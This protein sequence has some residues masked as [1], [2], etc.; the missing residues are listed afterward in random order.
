MSHD[1]DSFGQELQ[2]D[3]TAKPIRVNDRIY[4]QLDIS[5]EMCQMKLIEILD[6]GLPQKNKNRS[7]SPR[8]TDEDYYELM[9][10]CLEA[11]VTRLPSVG[12]SQQ[13]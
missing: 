5:R 10:R 12:K 3:S 4:Q 1:Y 2:L 11:E 8:H 9:K 13:G 7:Q 6:H